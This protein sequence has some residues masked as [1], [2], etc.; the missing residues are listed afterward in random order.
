MFVLIDQIN[1]Q[2]FGPFKSD[3]EARTYALSGHESVGGIPWG[4]DDWEVLELQGGTMPHERIVYRDMTA[5]ED[6][7]FDVEVTLTA[8]SRRASDDLMHAMDGGTPLSRV[9]DRWFAKETGMGRIK[10]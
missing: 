6:G 9:L 7:T 4:D 3:E 8:N 2:A 10:R 5:P 1:G